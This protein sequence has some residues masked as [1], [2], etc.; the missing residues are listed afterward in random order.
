[1]NSKTEGVLGA[2]LA[3]GLKSAISSQAVTLKL[4]FAGEVTRMIQPEFS[5]L[6]EVG[7]PVSGVYYFNVEPPPWNLTFEPILGQ[8]TI[9]SATVSDL[10][11]NAYGGD[12]A[13]IDGCG[14]GPSVVYG[15]DEYRLGCVQVEMEVSRAEGTLDEFLAL[16]TADFSATVDGFHRYESG[17]S[18]PLIAGV[19][20]TSASLVIAPDGDGDGV[21]DIVDNCAAAANPGQ[22]DSDHDGRGNACDAC[23]EDPENDADGDGVCGNSDNCPGTANPDQADTDGDGI[24][25]A[26]DACPND[27]ENDADGDGVC[28]DADNCPSMA[29]S[30]Q[31]DSDGDGSGDACDPCAN[32]PQNDADGDGVCGDVDAFPNSRGIGGNVVIDGCDTGVSEVVS[33]EGATL[34]DRIDRFAAGSRNHGDFVRQVTHFRNELR[35]LG[36]VSEEQAAAILRCASQS[37]LP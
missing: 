17:A 32:D 18:K 1:M 34:S 26:C 13:N 30:D 12:L 20:L 29:N 16:T 10:T 11:L 36:V 27:S 8:F 19:N 5:E 7:D 22:E 33:P 14:Q 6:I 4:E 2:V 21:A 31:A 3:L 15:G 23:P 35:K 28:G 37:N 25:D 24:G 9:G